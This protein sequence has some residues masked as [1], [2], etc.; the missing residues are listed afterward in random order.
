MGISFD[1][2][3]FLER[4][5]EAAHQAGGIAEY[6]A[7]VDELLECV[8]EFQQENTKLEEEIKQFKDT[9]EQEKRIIRHHETYI[10]LK[11]DDMK[12]IYCSVCWDK[13]RALIQMMFHGFIEGYMDFIEYR[14]NICKQSVSVD[15]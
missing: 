10:T 7:I 2:V 14:C 12:T 15:G 9:K 13:S 5:V 11:D 1:P 3:A 8:K 6:R 4:R